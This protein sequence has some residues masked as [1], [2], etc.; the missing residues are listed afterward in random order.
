MILKFKNVTS[1]QLHKLTQLID[2]KL[3]NAQLLL[4]A[5]PGKWKAPDIIGAT[6]IMPCTDVEEERSE[7]KQGNLDEGLPKPLA[8]IISMKV[9][10]TVGGTFYEVT[11]ILVECFMLHNVCCKSEDSR[12]TDVIRTP[13]FILQEIMEALDLFPSD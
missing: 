1:E 5:Y 6:R 7:V 4:T 11:V 10:N 12:H 13:A 2:S 9:R 8:R 3:Q